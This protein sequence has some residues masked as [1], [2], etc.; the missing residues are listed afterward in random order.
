MRITKLV[1]NLTAYT[2]GEQPKAMDVIKLNTNEN[3]YPPSPRCAEV[4]K[5]F[6]LEK[7]RRYPDS[8]FTELRVA[9][10]K[11]HHTTIDRIFVGNGSD[12]IL[13]LSTRAFVRTTRRF[14]RSTP[15]T[16][17]TSRSPIFAEYHGIAA[18]FR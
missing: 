13:S 5:N 18:I 8:V 17:S 9:L 7:L 2:P 6:D 10:A 14:G 4:L 1:K 11:L 3:A 16:H 15:H 12:E